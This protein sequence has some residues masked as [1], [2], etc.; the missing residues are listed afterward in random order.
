MYMIR[1]A[2]FCQRSQISSH[3]STVMCIH[4]DIN[5]INHDRPKVDCGAAA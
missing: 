5:D 3:C 4:N 2:D 1:D